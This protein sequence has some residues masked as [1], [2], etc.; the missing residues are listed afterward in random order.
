MALTLVQNLGLDDTATSARTSNICE[1]TT[2]ANDRQRIM[3]E[4]WFASTSTDA[5]ANWTFLD[6]FTRFPASAGG[7]CCD[8]IVVYNSHHRIWIWLL[9]YSSTA[10]GDNICVLRSAAETEFGSWYTALTKNLNAA[11]SKVWFDYPDMAFT[12]DNLFATFNVFLGDAWQRAV[13]FRFPLATLAA[14]T[15]LGYRWWST[16]NNGSIRLCRGPAL[17]CTWAATTLSASSECSSGR[18][19]HHHWINGRKRPPVDRGGLS[20]LR[21]RVV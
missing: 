21:G 10:N 14:G 20:R 5:G 18:T 16:T 11:G 17:S 3:T 13:V 2:A 12:N 4:N 9:Q 1:P 6:P 15:S 19:P 7:F 8:Q